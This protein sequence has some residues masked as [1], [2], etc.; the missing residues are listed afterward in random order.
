MMN[1]KWYVEHTKLNK[2][3]VYYIFD[4]QFTGGKQ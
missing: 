1:V 4:E 3:I 2:K